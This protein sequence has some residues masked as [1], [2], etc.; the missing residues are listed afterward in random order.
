M[1]LFQRGCLV[2]DEV[3]LLLHPLKSELNFP[4]GDKVALDLN[5]ERWLCAIHA[6]DAVFTWEGAGMSVDFKESSR[7]RA[8][9]DEL[10]A[11]VAKGLEPETK[12]LQ[13]SPHLVLLN[14]EWYHAHMK[15][16]MAQW[17]QLWLESQ[18]VAGLSSQQVFDYITAD[19]SLLR[20][21]EGGNVTKA[22]E[23][24]PLTDK[25][26]EL[27]QLSL[28]SRAEGGADDG[29]G[30]GGGAGE[31]RRLN[32]K[33]LKLLNIAGDWLRTYLPH[34]LQKIDRVS[35]G[36]LSTDEYKRL[37]ASEPNMP[38]SRFKLAIPFLGKDVPSQASEFA[39]PDVILGL[40]VLA[41]RY[42][43]LRYEEFQEDVVGLLRNDFEREVGPYNQR[44]SAKLY[45]EWV[46]QA[47]GVIKGQQASSEPAS[48]A[49]P[50]PAQLQRM[51]PKERAL[52]TAAA[53]AA[54]A[55]A[56]AGDLDD[57]NVVVP[58]WLLKQSNDEQMGKLYRLLRRLPGV[59]HWYLDQVVFPT[60]M[61]HQQVKI[62]ASGQELGGS[63][64]FSKRLG[65]S[66][67]PSDLLP[68]DLGRCGYEKGSDGKMLHIL[69]D[70]VRCQRSPSRASPLCLRPLPAAPS[71]PPSSRPLPSLSPAPS[72]A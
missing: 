32:T 25:A 24:D 59:I 56:M 6:L 60:Y 38:R 27:Y 22:T 47:G 8:I 48:S 36:L 14:T 2:M 42:E 43:G 40:S 57:E 54:H 34:T 1:K 5:P 65:F 61:K 66:G 41:Y 64:L 52:A 17:M 29:D 51:A 62:S 72:R 21:D 31:S 37:T 20:M 30:A 69:T 7:A 35:F 53:D 4:L 33:A 46:K 19:W 50:S 63:M 11:V 13:R 71:P 18:H 12:A 44:K 58:L 68:L 15:P 39:H 9:L 26:F 23:G 67:T 49:P 70:P 3:D 28:E 45:E 10:R 55:A 16:V